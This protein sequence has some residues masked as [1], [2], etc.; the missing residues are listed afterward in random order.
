MSRTSRPS[1]HTSTTDRTAAGSARAEP[2]PDPG[3]ERPATER[4]SMHRVAND[5]KS[6][7]GAA[8]ALSRLR[9]LERKHA[10]LQ[11]KP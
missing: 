9:M 11:D 10:Q 8:S 1:A 6:G 7:K 5:Q 2:G 3:T 4:R